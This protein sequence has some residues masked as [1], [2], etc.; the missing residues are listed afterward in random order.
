MY[1]FSVDFKFVH[2]EPYSIVWRLPAIRQRWFIGWPCLSSYFWVYSMNW[3][4]DVEY[5]FMLSIKCLSKHIARMKVAVS[6]L[7]SFCF[8]LCGDL[9]AL[10]PNMTTV[11]G[12]RKMAERY[13]EI[14]KTCTYC[15]SWVVI[16]VLNSLLPIFL[17][18]GTCYW[19]D[20]ICQTYCKQHF[21]CRNNCSKCREHRFE[22]LCIFRSERTQIS[23]W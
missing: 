13:V 7:S 12:K 3:I 20:S 2:L 4:S 9:V 10:Y 5:F 23:Y 21:C 11:N 19:W 18:I 16:A 6:L 14:W 8:G 22:V 17:I 1:L 15:C